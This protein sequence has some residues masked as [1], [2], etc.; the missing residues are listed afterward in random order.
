MR[1]AGPYTAT[2]V[3]SDKD[4]QTVSKLSTLNESISVVDTGSVEVVE[5]LTNSSDTGTGNQRFML[6]LSRG[7]S[8][9]EQPGLACF[10]RR[11]VRPGQERPIA[12]VLTATLSSREREPRM[13]SC[14]GSGFE[15]GKSYDVG[16]VFSTTSKILKKARLPSVAFDYAK[17]DIAPKAPMVIGAKIS[18]D[19]SKV[20]IKFSTSVAFVGR[21]NSSGK[22]ATNSSLCI[23]FLLNSPKL[24][25]NHILYS[26]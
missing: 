24:K 23:K 13:V 7:V 1:D 6:R 14:V 10:S 8:S 16:V 22:C 26:I 11:K 5:V 4:A 18:A 25:Y 9:F 21:K 3:V 15:R 12:R 19:W 17:K 20:V 2:C